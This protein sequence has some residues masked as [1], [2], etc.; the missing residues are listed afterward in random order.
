MNEDEE[1]QQGNEDEAKANHEVEELKKL[2]QTLETLRSMYKDLKGLFVF[3]TA[4][5]IFVEFHQMREK[6]LQLKQ[7]AYMNYRKTLHK[8]ADEE[9]PI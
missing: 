1:H 4:T 9:N 2:K 3:Y 7:A 5:G 6:L 8:I